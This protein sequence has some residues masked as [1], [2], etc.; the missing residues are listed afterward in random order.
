[1]SKHYF[2][3]GPRGGKSILA[4]DAA[5]QYIKSLSKMDK[6]RIQ[7]ELEQES[8]PEEGIWKQIKWNVKP[9]RFIFDYETTTGDTFTIPTK[10]IVNPE[11]DT[12]DVDFE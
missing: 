12:T 8:D 9:N 10:P 3:M 11:D 4:T 6:E 7:Q 1:M 5:K 2:D